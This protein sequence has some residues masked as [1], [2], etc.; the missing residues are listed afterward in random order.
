MAT[1]TATANS[2]TTI[3][4][5]LSN[6]KSWKVGTTNGACQGAYQGASRCGVMVFTGA[7]AALKSTLISQIQLTITC[8]ASGGS[9]SGKI[10]TFHKAN[11]QS[12]NTSVTG[13]AQVGDTL[14]TITGKFYD[15]TVT[16]TLSDSSNASLFNA[17]KSYFAAGN[18]VLV[19]YNG[20]TTAA[21]AERSSTHYVRVKTCVLT[22]S[23]LEPASKPS[24]SSTN[25]T[26]G[27][28]VTINTNRQTTAAT[29]TLRY[30]FFNSSGTIASNVTTSTSWTP[31]V[32]LAA[33]IP[34]ATSG[35][36]TIYCDT[37]VGGALVATESCVVTLAVPASVVPTISAVTCAEATSGLAAAFG[38][39]VRTKST[40]RVTITA[41]G[42]QGS[43]IK[44]YQTTA[45]GS[46]YS[47][48]TFT[49]GTLNTAGTNIISVKV[50]D[51]RGRTATKSVSVS[52]TDYSPPHLSKFTAERCNSAGTAAQVDGTK[53]RVSWNL[54]A[55]AVGGKNSVSYSLY[56]KT[57]SASAWTL[58][59]SASFGT[60]NSS[61]VTYT[62]T[63]TNYLLSPTFDALVSYDLK[64]KLTDYFYNLEQ[65]ISIGTK[66]VLLD[67]YRDGTGLAL[68]K[69]AEQSGK[70]G[71]GLPMVFASSAVRDETCT[72]LTNIGTNP[73]FLDGTVEWGK[74]GLSVAFFTPS[75][76]TGFTLPTTSDYWNVLNASN[77]S[78]EMFQFAHQQ[79]NG[80]LWVRG[81]NYSNGPGSWQKVAFAN[82]ATTFTAAVTC[83]AKLTC[84]AGLEVSGGQFQI[85]G[86]YY[87]SFQI[88]PT[89][90]TGYAAFEGSYVGE[91]NMQTYNTYGDS[92]N[93]R[94][95]SL[96]NSSAESSINNA[97]KLRY[98]DNGTWSTKRVYHQ[99]NLF[100]AASLP[101]S[102]ED[103]QICLVPI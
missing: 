82:I 69:I 23:Y 70:I 37:Y 46:S 43:T 41:S 15:N 12:L 13:S 55:Y 29:H 100:Y 36:G 32:S 65:V 57:A 92:E 35:W 87:P 95:L 3:G 1:F 85:S 75:R 21:D 14:G 39:Y 102:G 52:V 26:M 48:S 10:L 4:Y 64:L 6:S 50:T 51:S 49:T 28:A 98:V 101:S 89:A 17:M 76:G 2:N 73:S 86:G 74:K 84:T 9:S 42:S 27:S 67:F 71:V 79:P 11:Y 59:E 60:I 44:A 91:V 19:I 61:D 103:G 45:N 81:G 97:L 62:S 31:P 96:Y 68:G 8:S 33:Q 77:D 5:A 56:Y 63:Q 38:R 7:G 88:R 30:S 34:S 20:E 16:H 72:N 80:G 24:L 53:V 22:V 47:A 93:R 58:Y 99:G 83:A 94:I 66:R 40:L 90:G 18:S 78:S 25:V 54:S